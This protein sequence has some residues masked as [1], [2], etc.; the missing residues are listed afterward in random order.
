MSDNQR[1]LFEELVIAHQ[2]YLFS[3]VLSMVGNRD[4]A[5]DLTAK[6]F[7]RA[8]MAFKGFKQNCS[9]RT[10]LTTVA[11]N[12][13]KNHRRDA[14]PVSS[15]DEG[16]DETGFEPV[17]DDPTPEQDT[18]V[19]E[20][21]RSIGTLLRQVPVQFRACLVL[22]HVNQLSYEEISDLTRLPVTTIR[23]RIHHGKKIL[24]EL[25]EKNGMILPKE[26]EDE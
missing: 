14:K 8:F 12:L 2:D 26:G 19:C 16:N 25:C 7:M 17:D 20:Q 24:R 1:V 9:F 3:F 10:W 5:E 18:F 11:I 6:T 23:N 22:R 15:L 21:R 13:V 4:D